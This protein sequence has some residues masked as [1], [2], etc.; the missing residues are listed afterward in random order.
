[1]AI[2][3]SCTPGWYVLGW[4]SW[5]QC[6]LRK[7]LLFLSSLLMGLSK[8]SQLICCLC[9]RLRCLCTFTAFSW[10]PSCSLVEPLY[11][12]SPRA[13]IFTISSTSPYF[14]TKEQEAH[15]VTENEWLVLS[16]CRAE[17]S[18]YLPPVIGFRSLSGRCM[19]WMLDE[20]A[21]SRVS[22]RGISA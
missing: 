18:H 14:T 5:K 4:N 15:P 10:N 20:Q 11:K 2:A 17:F 19:Q 16:V 9:Y 3:L 1:M 22:S 13:C 21:Q 8:N 7:I 6:V 12:L